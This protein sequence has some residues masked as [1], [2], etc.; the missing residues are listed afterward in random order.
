MRD[1]IDWPTQGPPANPQVGYTTGPHPIGDVA[2]GDSPGERGLDDEADDLGLPITIYT[3][4]IQD[5]FQQ[6][7]MFLPPGAD[8]RWVAV[9]KVAWGFG[10]RI[11]R[12]LSGAIKPLVFGLAQK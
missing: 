10:G 6:N 4:S 5:Q 12:P 1:G 7:I 2:F 9:A 3:L 11:D 8:S